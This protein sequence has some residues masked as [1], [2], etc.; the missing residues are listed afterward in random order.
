MSIAIYGTVV[1]KLKHI[2]TNDDM[3]WVIE[4]ERMDETLK[5]NQW[6]IE[7]IIIYTYLTLYRQEKISWDLSALV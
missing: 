4:I 2:A 6:A 7:N 5:Q 1:I 3:I